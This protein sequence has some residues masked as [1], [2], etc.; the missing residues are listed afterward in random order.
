M[1]QD[2]PRGPDLT[3]LAVGPVHE[4]SLEPLTLLLLGLISLLVCQV[5]GPYALW[6]TYR[7][8]KECTELGIQAD[9]KSTAALVL[10]VMSTAILAIFVIFIALYVAMIAVIFL[11]YVVL[12][13][14]WIIVLVLAALALAI[15]A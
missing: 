7:Y 11:F 2:E 5:L 15:T 12:F 13:I 4:P 6:L 3:P 8:R 9:E 10:S 14:V 1:S